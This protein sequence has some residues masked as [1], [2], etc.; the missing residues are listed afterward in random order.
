MSSIFNIFWLKKDSIST[1][2]SV[3]PAWFATELR[4]LSKHRRTWEKSQH[5]QLLCQAR[6]STRKTNKNSVPQRSRNAIIEISNQSMTLDIYKRLCIWELIRSNFLV[7]YLHR[8]TR[9]YRGTQ[10]SVQ[11]NECLHIFHSFLS[12]LYSFLFCL[13]RKGIFNWWPNG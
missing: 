5:R 7:C 2:E 12:L 10:P 6:L 3:R 8:S 13:I 11:G 9:V 1:Y 4:A